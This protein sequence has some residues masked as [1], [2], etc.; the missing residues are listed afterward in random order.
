V[1]TV[2]NLFH[3]RFDESV[4]GRAW[5][6]TA[7]SAGFE[8]RD[9]YSLYPDFQIDVAE[10]QRT[11]EAA[12]VIVFQHPLHWYGA[13]P[14]MKKWVDDVLTYGWAYGGPN[15]LAEKYWLQAV[16]IGGAAD[17]YTSEGSRGHS[18]ETF[19]IPWSRVAAFCRMTWETPFV[20]HGPTGSESEA[21]EA[22]VQRLNNLRSM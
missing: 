4:I 5:A 3:P 20:W 13:P 8:V 22:Y 17:E 14:L 12:D 21:C 7:K 9:Q 19:L 15:R 10:E 11:A 16:S 2:I 6:D 18:A 1:K